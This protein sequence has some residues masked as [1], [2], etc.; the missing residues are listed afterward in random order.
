MRS[1]ISDYTEGEFLE[2]LKGIYYV[3]AQLYPTEKLHTRALLEFERLVEHP[4]GADL[5]CFPTKNGIKDSPEEFI[6]VIKEWRAE[7]GLPGFRNA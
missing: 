6:R 7:Q 3:D 4:L 1:T 2:F 5:I